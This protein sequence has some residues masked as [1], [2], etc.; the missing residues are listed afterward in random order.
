MERG[1][2]V[3]LLVGSLVVCMLAADPQTISLA[4]MQAKSKSA[5]SKIGYSR[6]FNVIQQHGSQEQQCR[7]RW[8]AGVYPSTF[9]VCPPETNRLVRAANS[10][11]S[12][13]GKKPH[14]ANKMIGHI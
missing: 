2:R 7:W 4:C 10:P 9:D 8:G 5:P 1:L 14:G 11:L 6:L 12:I 3:G 13:T